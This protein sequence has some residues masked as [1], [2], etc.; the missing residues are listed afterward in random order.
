[1]PYDEP[2]PDD[3]NMLV[4][5]VLPGDEQSIRNMATVFADEYARLG[6]D[7]EKLLNL[8]SQPFYSGAFAAWKVLG[9]SE[10]RTLVRES[11]RF[12]TGFRN[13]VK[14]ESCQT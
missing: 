4:G 14:E 12:W 1:M 6:Y 5:V 9:E 7:E 10:I 3:P 13:A 8:F 11:V 2:E